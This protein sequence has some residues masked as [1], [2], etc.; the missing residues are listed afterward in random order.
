MDAYSTLVHQI[1]QIPVLAEKVQD[2][3]NESHQTYLN[4][5]DPDWKQ[6]LMNDACYQQFQN[7]A[8]RLFSSQRIN[9]N[10]FRVQNLKDSATPLKVIIA[11]YCSMYNP[12]T[13]TTNQ[14]LSIT[15]KESPL[16]NMLSKALTSDVD[17]LTAKLSETTKVN[18]GGCSMCCQYCSSA[19]ESMSTKGVK[20]S[21]DCIQPCIVDT[22]VFDGKTLANRFGSQIKSYFPETFIAIL[23]LELN[24]RYFYTNKNT[25]MDFIRVGGRALKMV[26]FPESN[27]KQSKISL[28][29]LNVLAQVESEISKQAQYLVPEESKESI[30]K[31]TLELNEKSYE[32]QS[33]NSTEKRALE[34]EEEE[35]VFDCIPSKYQKT[36]DTSDVYHVQEE[37]VEFN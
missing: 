9:Q 17:P 8:K 36:W 11:G 15:L 4:L 34:E 20:L 26:A 21:F 35:E 27:L 6:K 37:T 18:F 25:S 28:G 19:I 13:K 23:Q 5:V 7:D 32:E 30:G 1:L 14:M 22:Y 3:V 29:N 33:S 24:V 12:Y 10:K 2:L 16:M 31:Y